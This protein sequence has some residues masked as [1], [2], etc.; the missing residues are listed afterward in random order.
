MTDKPNVYNIDKKKH[1][2]RATARYSI[3]LLLNEFG[4]AFNRNN[5]RKML[6]HLATEQPD[7][8]FDLWQK[9]IGKVN[10]DDE[11]TPV[12]KDAQSLFSAFQT[13]RLAE[14]L[15]SMV[16]SMKREHEQ[17][18]ADREGQEIDADYTVE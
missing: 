3:K 16:V 6:D 12:Q 9:L 4:D 17:L 15:S 10:L 1:N 11:L 18:Q 2:H 5:G 14:Q 13:G 7:K 8:F